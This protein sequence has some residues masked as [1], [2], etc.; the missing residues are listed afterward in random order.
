MLNKELVKKAHA[1]VREIKAQYPEVDY[2]FQFGL[3]LSYLYKEED[4]KEMD[5]QEVN[6]IADKA[7]T[8]INVKCN[9]WSKGSLERVYV[10]HITGSK[11]RNTR[12]YLELSNHVVTG[13][14]GDRNVRA[15]FDE[16][17]SVTI[18]A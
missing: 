8:Q 15:L 1:M 2:R 14:D 5:M 7:C 16:L 17:E 9:L 18:T 10:N 3:C 12:G 13:W 6:K 11:N 4:N